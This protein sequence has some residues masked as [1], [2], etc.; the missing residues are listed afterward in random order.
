MQREG[1]LKRICQHWDSNILTLSKKENLISRK[2]A[3]MIIDGRPCMMAL[4]GEYRD[5]NGLT[6]ETVNKPPIEQFLS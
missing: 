5:D 4:Y 1:E 3:K 2:A 6:S